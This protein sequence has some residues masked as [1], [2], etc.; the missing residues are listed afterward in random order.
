MGS[1][2]GKVALVTAGSRG[3]G[4]GIVEALLA[5]GAQ[6]A[7]TGRSAEKGEKAL[8]EIGQLSP[9]SGRVSA[10]YRLHRQSVAEDEAARATGAPD[11][12][13]KVATNARDQ[14]VG[15]SVLAPGAAE[16]VGVLGLL[17]AKGVAFKDIAKIAL[18][19]PSL[20]ASLVRLAE[21]NID[22]GPTTSAPLQSLQRLR[23]IIGR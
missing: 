16:L 22:D 6:V 9:L 13:V 14:I 1:L 4:R 18:P 19:D 3:I 20:T 15:A 21:R 5:E 10:G 7:L 23:R 12:L 2:D 11:G 8:A 17:M